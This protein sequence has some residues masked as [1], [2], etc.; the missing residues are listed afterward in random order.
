MFTN[1]S[2]LGFFKYT[3]FFTDIFEQIFSVSLP[4]FNPFNY[5]ANSF[6]GTSY[7]ISEIVLPVG[8]SFY[9]F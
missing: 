1:L 6:L 2:I 4:V 7:N 9:T 3:Y 8:I 5:L